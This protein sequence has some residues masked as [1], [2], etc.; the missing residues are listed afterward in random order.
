LFWQITDSTKKT[1]LLLPLID[2]T[3]N[4]RNKDINLGILGFIFRYKSTEN[5]K[6]FKFLYPLIEYKKTEEKMTFRISPLFWMKQTDDVSYNTL[7]PI[8]YFKKTEDTRFLNLLFGLYSYKKSNLDTEKSHRILWSLLYFN[9]STKGKATRLG[10][11]LYKNIEKESNTEKAIFPFYSYESNSSG[12]NSRSFLFKCF[13]SNEL[14]IEGSNEKY[15][16]IKVLW[17]IRLGSNYNYLHDKG[18]M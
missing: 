9:K 5:E 11:F 15:K 7:L 4:K 13:Q 3:R 12:K 8:Y 10:Y 1:T 6:S 18:L 14:P 16:E 2:Y 17:F